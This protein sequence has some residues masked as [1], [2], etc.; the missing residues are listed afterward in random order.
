MLYLQPIIKQIQ[1]MKLSYLFLF[2][3]L[4]FSTNID[5]QNPVKWDFAAK[6]TQEAEYEITFTAKVDQ[7][8]S[9]YSQYTD[10]S[11]PIPTAFIFEED[12]NLE[13]IGKPIETGKKKEAFDELFGVNVIKFAGVVTF[14]QKV[15]A[16]SS[17][18]NVA[19]HGWGMENFFELS[20]PEMV[21]TV[22]F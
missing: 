1:F 14:T 12:T 5:A 13:F 2:F 4:L 21:K 6:K 19:H 18:E 7:G 10:P 20:V 9:I 11:G 8:W 16:K 17:G 15:K 3:S 22:L